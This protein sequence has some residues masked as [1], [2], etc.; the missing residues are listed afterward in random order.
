MWKMGCSSPLTLQYLSRTEEASQG[1]GVQLPPSVSCKSV[2]HSR[3][4][5]WKKCGQLAWTLSPW[6]VQQWMS[7]ALLPPPGS[8]GSVWSQR[9]TMEEVNINL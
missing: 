4:Q 2:W 7:S 9:P 5:P 8:R 3:G 6:L 1:S